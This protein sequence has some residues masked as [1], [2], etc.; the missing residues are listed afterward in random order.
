[1]KHVD[2][3]GTGRLSYARQVLTDADFQVLIRPD[4][5]TPAAEQ[6][7]GGEYRTS[8]N[9]RGWLLSIKTDGGLRWRFSA[10][11][12]TPVTKDSTATLG[13]AGRVDGEKF[14]V[15]ATMDVNNGSSGYDVRFYTSDDGVTWSQLGSTV[16]TA[17]AT[18]IYSNSGSVITLGGDHAAAWFTGN[19]YEVRLYSTIGGTTN[20]VDP[21]PWDW[22]TATYGATGVTIVTPALTA[23][24]QDSYPPRVLL[25]ATDIEDDDSVTLYRQVAG[26]RTAVRGASDV[27]AGDTA[28]VRVD[29]ELPFGVPVTYVLVLNEDEEYTAG[30]AT[31]ALPGGKV[32]LTDAISGAAA[33][34]EILSWPE[35]RYER[36]SSTYVVGGRNLAVLGLQPGFSASIE[37]ETATDSARENFASLLASAT[38]GTLQLRQDGSYGGVDCYLVVL[39]AVE[40]RRDNTD[41]TDERRRWVLD[42]IEVEPWAGD[43]EAAAFTL[44]DIADA[45]PDPLTLDDLSDDYATLLAIAQADFS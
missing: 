17:T 26:D 42:V 23:D 45:Y 30:P 3:A 4:D 16:T 32:A 35:K 39:T 29:A 24:E 19:V 43:L 40:A 37:I 13:S 34:V 22:S 7:I 2:F 27:I 11:G 20:L 8:G 25:T 14:W 1:M 38:Q 21:D 18:S 36:P 12:T 31:Y 10:D 9:N 41:G 5:L 33:E 28:L 6:H 15:R 44:Q